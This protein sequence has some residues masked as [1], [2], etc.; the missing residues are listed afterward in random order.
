MKLLSPDVNKRMS[1]NRAAHQAFPAQVNFPQSPIHGG[2]ES[3][4][5]S[6]EPPLNILDLSWSKMLSG[7]LLRS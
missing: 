5:T 1:R 7:G 4:E 2:L 6:A 3:C